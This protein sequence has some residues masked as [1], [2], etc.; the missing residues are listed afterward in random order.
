MTPYTLYTYSYPLTLCCIYIMYLHIFTHTHTL[1]VIKYYYLQMCVVKLLMVIASLK[2]VEGY[3]TKSE[4]RFGYGLLYECRRQLLHG[5]NKYHLLVG[6]DIPKFTFTQFSYQLEHYLNCKQF[7]NITVLH[8]ICY[9]LVPL[10]INYR[11]KE[12]QCQREISQILELDLLSIIQNS[13]K[14][15]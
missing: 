4:I 11:T 8:S 12:Q 5:L 13:I 1:E 2:F 14:V 9:Y 10:C 15:G 3:S 7:I 6:L